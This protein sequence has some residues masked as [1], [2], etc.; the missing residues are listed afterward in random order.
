MKHFIPLFISLFIFNCSI[1]MLQQ[2]ATISEQ[3]LYDHVA[4][5]A[6][7]ELE[8]RKPGTLTGKQAATYIMEHFNH[9]GLTLLGED[10]Y[11]YFDVVTSVSLGPNNQLTA[12]GVEGIPGETYTPTAFSSNK[13]LDAAMVF[14][15]YGFQIEND[16]MQWN[17]YQDIDAD[18]KWVMVLRGTPENDARQSKYD[19]YSALRHKLLVARDNGA[20]GLIFVSGLKFDA[21]D[22]LIDLRIDRNLN[23]A[24]LP[25]IHANR[26]LADQLLAG[27]GK[28][29]EDLE[30]VLDDQLKPQSLSLDLEISGQTEVIQQEVT[31]Q[32][33]I[34]MLPGSDP[35][36][37]DEFI[38]M[39]AHYDH[40]GWGGK[41]SGSRRPDT[42]A[43][44]NGA[45]DNAS[46]VAAVLE[47]A[48]RLAL[49]KSAPRR[50]ILF[51]A[52]GAEEMG[53]LGSKFFTS[54]PLI[55][56]KNIKQMFNLDMVGRLDTENPTLTVG[57]TGTA[58]G[59][60]NLLTSQAEER[61]FNL[62][63][64]PDGYGPSDHASFY[65]EDI[66]VLFFFTGITE[67]YHTPADDVETINFT[68]EKEISDYAYDLITSI[69]SMD[70]T[71]TY[72]EAGPKTPPKA[73]KRGKVKM[74]IIPDFAAS[75]A[76]GFLIG[77]IVPG[78]PAAM[79]GMKKGD[80]MVALEGLSVMNVYDYMGRMAEVKPGQRITVEVMR[81]DE[82]VILIVQ[83]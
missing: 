9:I 55:E 49:G 20:A 38:V 40:L 30:T 51:M 26:E 57:G 11:Q 47:I 73:G 12:E 71:F 8:G 72:Q 56:K 2:Q 39:G 45:D 59:I 60:E 23:M 48:E 62:S 70:E 68:G 74:G 33:V 17:D 52:F 65:V 31:T 53:L 1:P 46:G 35:E 83:L 81:G 24:T 28:T 61:D 69:A 34:A 21:N 82:K 5:L 32:N 41:G 22:E 37:K 75:D 79:A 64:T 63:M 13:S 80:V 50:S 19:K 76:K 27:S 18:G 7:D 44:H 36:L 66:P 78:G 54:N 3:E 43:V 29:I 16:S 10:G 15:G 77:G 6:S 67:E 25:V 42:S 4:Y 58:D 14:A